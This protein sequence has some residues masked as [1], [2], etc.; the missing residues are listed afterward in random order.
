MIEYPNDLSHA[1]LEIAVSQTGDPTGAFNLYDIDV[2]HDGSDFVAHDCPC[3]GDQPLIGA[4]V[5]GFYISTNS[6]GVTSFEGAQ[7]YVLSKKALA[8]G[9]LRWFASIS[10]PRAWEQ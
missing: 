6:F 3:L 10:S 9:D 5:N 2:S 1:H 8:A 4:D 7:I